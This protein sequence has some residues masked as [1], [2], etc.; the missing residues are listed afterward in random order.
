MSDLPLNVLGQPLEACCFSPKT[1]YFRDGYCRTNQQDLG[2]HVICAEITDAF[3][4]YTLAKGNDLITPKPE[5]EFP[6][7]KAGDFW[8]LCAIRWREAEQAGVAPPVKLA[9][10]D[11]KALKYVD[12]GLLQ[13]YAID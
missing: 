9:A 13:R 4:Q 7:L 6:G 5:W 3:L 10:C 2:S 8:C 12:L 1:G 11:S